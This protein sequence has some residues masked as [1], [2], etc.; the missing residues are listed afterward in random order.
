[1]R[2]LRPVS[3]ENRGVSEKEKKRVLKPLICFYII[4]LTQT[5]IAY[6]SNHRRITMQKGFTWIFKK[7]GRERVDNDIERVGG[8]GSSNSIQRVIFKTSTS[9]QGSGTASD[10]T[11]PNHEYIV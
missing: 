6:G 8:G 1:M 2:L 11:D 3:D 4:T 10:T 7:L 5:F 9:M